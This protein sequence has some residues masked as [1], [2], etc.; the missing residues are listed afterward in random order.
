MIYIPGKIPIRIHPFFLIIILG[1]AWL[2]TGS[3]TGMALGAI[4]MFFSVLLHELGHATTALAFGQHAEID[5]MALGGLT[6]RKGSSLK[7]WQELLIVF[8]GPLVGFILYFLSSYLLGIINIKNNPITAYILYF[9][10]SINLVW[11]IFNLLPILPLDGGRLISIALE[12]IFGLR[13]LKAAYFLSMAVAFSIGAYAFY[14]GELFIGSICF[15]FMFES[16]RNWRGSLDMSAQDQNT[17]LQQLYKEA[18][19]DHQEGRQTEALRKFTNV[20]NVTK[21]GILNVNATQYIAEI[22]SS[23]GHYQEAFDLL[24]PITSKLNPNSLRLMQHLAYRLGDC[25]HALEIGTKAYQLLP[26]YDTAFINAICCAS[27]AQIKPAI[28]WLQCAIREGMPN[29]LALLRKSEF[30]KIRSEPAFQALIK[31]QETAEES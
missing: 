8:N 31:Q 11:T 20:R 2:W 23:Q 10:S 5:L 22:L 19:K 27:Q 21:S 26:T 9:T 24:T 15:I 13:G 12:G 16:Y 30:D 18:E 1:F 6:H 4:I 29:A 14:K 3:I 7:V 17:V 28:G 25:K